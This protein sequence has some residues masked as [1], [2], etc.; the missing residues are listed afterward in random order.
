M[1]K[2]I[3]LGLVLVS[4]FAACQRQQPDV[5]VPTAPATVQQPV[6][7]VNPVTTEPVYRGKFG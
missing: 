4:A 5:F 1:S 6:V 7:P 2:K 3:V